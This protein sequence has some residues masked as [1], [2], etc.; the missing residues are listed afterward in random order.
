L[1][2]ICTALSPDA[3]EAAAL[4]GIDTAAPEGAGRAAAAFAGGRLVHV[5][6]VPVPVVDA[7]DAGDAFTGALGVALLE[8][9][10]LQAAVLFATAASHCAVTATGGRRS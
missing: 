10:D 8:R 1:L 4:T 6:P 9:Q 2:A 5:P 3:R 7:T